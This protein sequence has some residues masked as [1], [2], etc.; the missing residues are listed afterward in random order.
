M[1]R[2]IRMPGLATAI[3]TR[4]AITE[5]DPALV[6][7]D[8]GAESC[9][10][11]LLRWM[12]VSRRSGW[13]IAFLIPPPTTELAF[14]GTLAPSARALKRDCAPARNSHPKESPRSVWTAG[15]S[16][17]CAWGRT[18]EPIGNPFCY[19][20]ERTI[21]ALKRVHSRISPE[22]LYELTGVQ[23]LSLN[24]LVPIGGRPRT[25]N[26]SLPWVNVPEFVMHWLGGRRVSEYTNATH[27]QL[28]GVKDQAWCPE[29]FAAAGLEFGAAPPLVRPGTDIGRLQGPAG[30]P[31][32]ISRNQIDR[33]RLPRYRV[34]DCWH[35]GTGRRLGISSAPGPGRWWAACLIRPASPRLREAQTSATKV[36]SA[37]R[38]IS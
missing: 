37:A 29:I 24:T 35:S 34:G 3:E 8:L 22:R 6:A 32:G 13:F 21:A 18:A 33:A 25:R 30:F 4:T 14:A 23:I 26:K 16:T 28:L 15:P 31:A 17:T 19:R 5:T 36:E 27:T 10:V 38:F 7:V 2:G 11:S 12:E 9:R 20:D 1:L